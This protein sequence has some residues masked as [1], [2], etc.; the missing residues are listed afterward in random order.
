MTL[1]PTSPPARDRQRSFNISFVFLF[2]F[3]SDVLPDRSFLS[4]FVSIPSRRTSEQSPSGFNFRCSDPLETTGSRISGAAEN[5]IDR[6]AID[7]RNRQR[8]PVSGFS[9]LKPLLNLPIRFRE[10]FPIQEKSYDDEQHQLGLPWAV[11]FLQYTESQ[12]KRR[13]AE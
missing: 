6:P 1:S 9:S 2:I 10:S 13:P 11:F 12:A 8:L 4:I 7:P 3:S 5:P